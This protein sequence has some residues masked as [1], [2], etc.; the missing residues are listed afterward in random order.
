[1]RIRCL[2]VDYFKKKF[3]AGHKWISQS[4][5]VTEG[6]NYSNL[7]SVSRRSEP[8]LSHSN[9]HCHTKYVDRT[10]TDTTKTSFLDIPK[11]N[12][13]E[14]PKTSFL[15]K[16]NPIF[17]DKGRP[18]ILA[19]RTEDQS[20]ISRGIFDNLDTVMGGSRGFG[21]IGWKDMDPNS[22]SKRRNNHL[23]SR[24]NHESVPDVAA[25]LGV[26]EQDP[27]VDIDG[28]LGERNP[29]LIKSKTETFAKHFRNH[30]SVLKCGKQVRI[31]TDSAQDPRKY[32]SKGTFYL[33]R[34]TPGLGPGEGR[35]RSSR[36]S[37]GVEDGWLKGYGKRKTVIGDIVRDGD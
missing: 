6:F 5:K 34:L 14:K 9:L 27:T 25:Y 29:T 7:G 28:D 3:R 31:R 12:Y 30:S 26:I 1:M 10:M 35:A 15:D 23:Y 24:P 20:K 18:P 13:S 21:D 2:K 32:V 36:G 19:I 11:T 37:A 8:D 22:P 4:S 17:F 16:T 33:N